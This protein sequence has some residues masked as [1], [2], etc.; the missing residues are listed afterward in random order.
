MGVTATAA[1]PIPVKNRVG[2]DQV[3]SSNGN[4][5]EVF[6]PASASVITSIA[7]DSQ[8]SDVADA[9][10]AAA[11]ALESWALTPPPT[12]AA[13]LVR[14]ASA[15][16]QEAEQ[17]AREMVTEMGKPLADARNEVQR[18]ADNLRLYAGEALRL[19]GATFPSDDPSMLVMTVLDP[20]GVVGAITPWNF[21][22]SLASRKLGPALAAGNT[23]V[24][25]PSSMT[26]LMGERLAA[27]FEKAGLPGGVLNV[28]HGFGAGSLV[29]GD[30]RVRAITFTGSTAVGKKIH[31]AMGLGR[32]PQLELGGNNPVVVLND[33]DPQRA[34][35]LIVRSAFALSGQA[36]TGAGR[37]ILE[38]AIHDEVLELTAT[39][40][41]ALRVGPGLTEGV[42]LGPLIDERAVNT[43]EQVVSDSLAAGA[44]LVC[45]GIRLQGEP[46]D[47]GWFFPPTILADVA[48]S[49]NVA[50]TEVFGPVI[51]F[52]RVRDFD[53]ALARANDTEYGLTSSICTGSLANAQRFARESQA[54]VV[55]INRPTIGT[56]ISAPFGGVKESGTGIHKEQLG[57]TVM[58]FYTQQRTVFFGA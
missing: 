53:E 48:S 50:C 10:A 11:A 22:L 43:M 9:V 39:A 51:G 31:A 41:Q 2:G 16:E 25:K 33:A 38:E 49:M 32:R 26:P 12:R 58:D 42:D 14:A 20:V 18:T 5:F 54:G 46:Y 21:P 24:F 40:A 45:G 8:A 29:V 28:V 36:C 27:A 13:I 17:I 35:N 19:Q 44:R 47:A 15:M 1:P 57:P 34:A 55:R 23:V 52:E 30:E 37:V 3:G 6:N 7:P 56:A 4:V